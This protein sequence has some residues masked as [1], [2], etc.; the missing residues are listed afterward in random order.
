MPRSLASTALGQNPKNS[1][2]QNWSVALPE[3]DFPSGRFYEYTLAPPE[4]RRP[5]K[6]RS[7]SGRKLGR[8]LRMLSGSAAR[9]A[10]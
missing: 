3:A 8:C 5:G 4:A 7:L 6:L 2:E 1:L 10:A 9:I